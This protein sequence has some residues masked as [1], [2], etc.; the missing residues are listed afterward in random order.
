MRT[1]FP[2]HPGEPSIF[3][4]KPPQGTFEAGSFLM[5]ALISVLN[6][7]KPMTVPELTAIV[8]ICSIAG[9][10]TLLKR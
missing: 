5:V 2:K 1:L 9:V 4:K 10:V 8:A 7:D 3:P 6:A